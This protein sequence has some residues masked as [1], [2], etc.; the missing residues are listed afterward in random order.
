M[1]FII[2]DPLERV[3]NRDQVDMSKAKYLSL[4]VSFYCSRLTHTLIMLPL[5]I[6]VISLKIETSS[7]KRPSIVLYCTVL[8][9]LAER[10]YLI[11]L[12]TDVRF[13]SKDLLINTQND[14][15]RQQ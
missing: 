13:I 6:V 3:E 14:P 8:Y 5:W 15:L 4:I 10:I 2:V 1:E 7:L 9:T 12:V 11:L